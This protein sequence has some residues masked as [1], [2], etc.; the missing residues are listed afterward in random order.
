VSKIAIMIPARNEE[1]NIK[2]TIECLLMLDK[3]L[4]K[5]K[6]EIVVVDDGSKDRTVE[7]LKNLPVSIV[8]RV[9]RGYSALGLP[10]LAETHNSGF[11]YISDN[12]ENIKYLMVVG[13]DTTFDENYIELLLEEF[14]KNE[15]LV[16]AAGRIE[17][18]KAA[19][20]AV[21]GSGRIIRYKFWTEFG[22]LLP[23]NYYA[24]ESYPIYYA[25]MKGYQT[26]TVDNAIMYTKRE[27]LALVDWKRYGIQMKEI[28]YRWPYVMHRAMREML[29]L[30]F[31]RAFRLFIGF[32]QKSVNKYP[33]DMREY[34]RNYQKHQ[35]VNRLNIFKSQKFV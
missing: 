20:N 29:K 3:K 16:M 1:N 30:R 5:Y 28:G 12:F 26:K 32:F 24:W 11:K 7:I 13:A 25:L 33:V 9:D 2:E 34:V 14:D 19:K 6:F 21:R 27:P 31:K 23:T 10:E 8:E 17:N 4:Q 15:N 18:T 35:I 22:E